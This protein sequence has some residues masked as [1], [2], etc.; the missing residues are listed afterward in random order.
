MSAGDGAPGPPQV[1]VRKSLVGQKAPVLGG[2]GEKRPVIG[3]GWLIDTARG[4][5]SRAEFLTSL[6]PQ[7]HH[8]PEELCPVPVASESHL[9]TCRL[10]DQMDGEADNT[11]GASP[12]LCMIPPPPNSINICVIYINHMTESCIRFPGLGDPMR[13][14]GRVSSS[15]GGGGGGQTGREGAHQVLCHKS[16]CVSRRATQHRPG[17]RSC[18]DRGNL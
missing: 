1:K 14:T 17:M 3:C 6:L 15:S 12:S 13:T 18:C 11:L 8:H 9:R 2:V 4:G 7:S 10:C 16:Y 5:P